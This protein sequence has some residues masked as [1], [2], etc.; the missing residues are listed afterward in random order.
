MD[1]GRYPFHGLGPEVGT[2][3]G[4]EEIRN[5]EARLTH[6]PHLY[7]D[8]SPSEAYRLPQTSLQVSTH[9]T[10]LPG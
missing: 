8:G 9:P 6:H 2:A 5:A 10:I 4:S 3:A 7:V 1:H